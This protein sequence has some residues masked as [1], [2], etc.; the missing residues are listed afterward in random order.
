MHLFNYFRFWFQ[1]VEI[2]TSGAENIPKSSLAGRVMD[3]ILSKTNNILY[4]TWGLDVVLRWFAYMFRLVNVTSSGKLADRAKIL[5]N[6]LTEYRAVTRWTGIPDTLAGIR[7]QLNESDKGSLK[8][9]LR[10]TQHIL[11]LGYYPMDHVA[12]LI[13]TK[14]VPGN[15]D[16][17]WRY[18]SKCWMYWIM[19]EL[20]LLIK[21]YPTMSREKRRILLL[22]IV[23]NLCDL[24]LAYHWSVKKSPLNDFHIGVSG[25]VGSSCALA[26][27]WIQQ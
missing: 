27:Q 19:I 6:I 3:G 21:Q 4:N 5:S 18:G 11:M 7:S 20:Y 9:A 22:K 24:V 17:L 12:F 8:Y 1:F 25:V 13:D 15:S 10:L 2:K 23:R 26:L 16:G 14:V